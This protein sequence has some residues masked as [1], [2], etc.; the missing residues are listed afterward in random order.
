MQFRSDEVVQRH[1]RRIGNRRHC[2][3]HT[4]VLAV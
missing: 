3:F 1:R 2:L 4:R